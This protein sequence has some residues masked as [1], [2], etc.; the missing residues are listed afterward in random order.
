MPNY[1]SHPNIDLHLEIYRLAA[2][3]VR[4]R[5]VFRYH[6]CACVLGSS[7]LV[8]IYLATR[9]IPG[10]PTFLW[11]LWPVAGWSLTLLLHFLLVFV[12]GDYRVSNQRRNMLEAELRRISREG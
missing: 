9:L 2:R 8:A 1:T 4:A 7:L 3:R 6:L 5:L 11:F 10:F 12:F